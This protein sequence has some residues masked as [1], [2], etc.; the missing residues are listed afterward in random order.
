MKRI[1]V[2][3]R[4]GMTQPKN[5]DKALD[6]LVSGGAPKARSL[7]SMSTSGNQRKQA[8]FMPAQNA[9]QTARPTDPLKIPLPL[10]RTPSDFQARQI[11]NTQPKFSK[12]DN[13]R[14]R[15]EWRKTISSAKSMIFKGN[16]STTKPI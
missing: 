7:D 14:V 16:P 13:M 9:V 12:A 6:N 8:S 4:T 15:P 3:G 2:K 11:P 1:Q 10:G 5:Y